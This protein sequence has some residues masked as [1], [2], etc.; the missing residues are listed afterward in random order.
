MTI[1]L[2]ITSGPIDFIQ[3]YKDH[4]GKQNQL[5]NALDINPYWF[6]DHFTGK[7]LDALTEIMKGMY[8]AGYYDNSDIQSDYFDTAYYI[9]VNIGKWDKPYQVL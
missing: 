2:T 7:A 6:Q 3:N 4:T 5:I 9:D 1:C 8:S